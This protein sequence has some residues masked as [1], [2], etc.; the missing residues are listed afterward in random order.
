MATARIIVHEAVASKFLETVKAILAQKA[1]DSSAL[2]IVAT[3]ASKN[4]IQGVLQ[5]AISKGASVVA[6]AGDQNIVPGNS[7]IPT[8]LKDVDPATTMWNDETFGPIVAFTTVENE[9]HAINM[10]NSSEYGLSASVFTQDLR[11]ALAIARQLQSG[12]AFHYEI[13]EPS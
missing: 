10:A 9:E 7:I 5:E 1:S 12:Y 11:K 6:G 2:P 4:R 13:R 3:N 8:I